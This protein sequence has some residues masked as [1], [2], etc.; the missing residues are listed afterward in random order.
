MKNSILKLIVLCLTLATFSSCSS[1]DNNNNTSRSTESIEVII[2][3]GTPSYYSNNIIAEDYLLPPTSGFTCG[4]RFTGEDTSS[5][6]FRLNLGMQVDPCPFTLGV[7]LPYSNIVTGPISAFVIVP[8]ITFDDAAANNLNF[9]I[10]NFGANVGDDI[11]MTI[12]GTYY[13]VSD[14]SPHTISI[15]IHAHRD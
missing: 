2:D 13:I 4:F 6:V 15:T 3:S 8:G 5:N 9:T 12:S 1:D 14:P 10:T 7:L 11:D